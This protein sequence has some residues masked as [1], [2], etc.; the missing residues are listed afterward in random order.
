MSSIDEGDFYVKF[1]VRNKEDAFQWILVAVYGATQ[2]E[3]KEAF[4]TELVNSCRKEALPMVIGGDFNIIRKPQEKNN[5]NFNVKWS[6]L[7]NAVINSLNLREIILSGRKFTWANA[8]PNPTYEKLDRV[9]V[10][11]EWEVKNPLVTVHALSRDLSD[12]T[13]ML[14]DTCKGS[15][16]DSQPLFKFEL[17]W[18]LREDFQKLLANIWTKDIRG[19]TNIA[20]WQNKI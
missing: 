20:R 1:H 8:M 4:L 16:K 13:P 2:E 11:T 3:Y 7:F 12:H 6:F 14:L 17:G 19:A 15:H 18:L 9:L 5:A 10:S